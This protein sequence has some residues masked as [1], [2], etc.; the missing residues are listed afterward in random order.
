MPAN[1]RFY[2]IR[3]LNMLRFIQKLKSANH[4]GGQAQRKN[5]QGSIARY[6]KI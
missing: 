1:F 3:E 2:F 4:H 5:H 6:I